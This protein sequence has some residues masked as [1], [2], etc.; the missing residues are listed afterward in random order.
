MY[1]LVVLAGAALLTGGYVALG[2]LI[3]KAVLEAAAREESAPLPA[4]WLPVIRQRVPAVNALTEAQQERLLHAVRDL[5]AACHWEGCGG[6][7][8]TQEMQLVI[9]AQACLLTLE[10]AG[11]PY[12][13]LRTVLVYP[14]TFRPV[15]AV[16]PR[17]TTRGTDPDPRLPELGEAWRT[18]TVVVS[19]D[20]ALAG[21][22]NPSDGR[23]VIIHEF[24]HLIDFQY[25]LVRGDAD[26]SLISAEAGAH[27]PDPHIPGGATWRRVLAES[28]ERHCTQIEAGTPT[29]LGQYAA[30]NETE[31]F[32]VATEAFFEVP[33]QLRTAYPQLYSHFS[34]F[35]RQD[36][37]HP[38]A[39]TKAP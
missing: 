21:G 37:A 26:L 20:A 36:P 12:P 14:D 29:L 35:F 5:I 38:P 33:A 31:F 6:L 2:P 15:R 30:T 9:A 25:D 24:A 1:G 39:E 8:L 4:T 32:A 11:D 17:M 27:S 7:V 10:L 3:R 18:G 13:N 28:Y 34:R 19:W 16:D 22:S 23:N